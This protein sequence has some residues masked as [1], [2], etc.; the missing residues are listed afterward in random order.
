LQ[1]P[2]PIARLIG[3]DQFDG[4]SSDGII[5]P[6][7]GM[8]EYTNGNFLSNDTLFTADFILPRQSSLSAGFFLP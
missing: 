1:A 7:V 5:G 4:L 3:T 6:T 8:E 2:I